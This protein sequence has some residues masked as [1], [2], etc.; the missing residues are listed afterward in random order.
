VIAD[1]RTFLAWVLFGGV[2]TWL[3]FLIGEA[4]LVPI[5]AAGNRGP[6]KTP[7]P[8]DALPSSGLPQG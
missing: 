8:S 3:F 7:Q 1:E 4:L 5:S 2:A 6:P